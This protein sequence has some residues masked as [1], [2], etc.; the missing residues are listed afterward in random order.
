MAIALV[1]GGCL[2]NIAQNSDSGKDQQYKGAKLIE[3]EDGEGEVRDIVTYPGGDRV[4]WKVI[5]LP[6]GQKGDLRIRLRYR[7]AR[8]GMEVVFAV[9]D[10]WF[11]RVAR[12]KRKK[13]KSQRGKKRATVKGATGRYYIQIYAPTRMDAASYKLSIRFKERKLPHIPTDEEMLAEVEEPPELPAIP[14]PAA[15]A[16]GGGAQAAGG[17]PAGGGAAPAPAPAPAAAG[18]GGPGAGGATEPGAGDTVEPPAG[19]LKA[20]VV[21]LRASSGGV[22]VTLNRGKS[23]GVDR[24]WSGQVLLGDTDNPLADGVFKIIKV[25]KRESKAKI[26]LTIDQVKANRRVLLTPP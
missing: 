21:K 13:S 7:S 18:P 4:D 16:A 25:T 26:K 24:G 23:D 22:V 1:T 10:Q 17:G 2:R 15:P 5:E 9:F 14:E 11:H 3:L 20:K 8:P 19:P 12:T 6:E